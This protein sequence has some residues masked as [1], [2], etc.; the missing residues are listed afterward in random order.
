LIAHP[1]VRITPHI[2]WSNPDINKAI[3]QRLVEN[4]RRLGAGEPLLGA[5]A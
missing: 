1:R 2:S 3:M 4:I 5:I